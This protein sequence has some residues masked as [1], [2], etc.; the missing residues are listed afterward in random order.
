MLLRSCGIPGIYGPG[1][2]DWYL[3]QKGLMYSESYNA[4]TP[5]EPING[6]QLFSI[7]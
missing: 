3:S 2:R 4:S 6:F 7:P 1:Q 5:K